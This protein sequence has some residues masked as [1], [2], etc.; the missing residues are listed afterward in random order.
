MRRLPAAAGDTLF[1]L[2]PFGCSATTGAALAGFPGPGARALQG[3]QGAGLDGRYYLSM[4]GA[5]DQWGLYVYDTRWEGWIPQDGMKALA[6]ARDGGAAVSPW[7]RTGC[8]GA[9]TAI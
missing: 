9:W 1:Y 4:A 8:C 3:G 5:Q 7:T 2:N 6:F